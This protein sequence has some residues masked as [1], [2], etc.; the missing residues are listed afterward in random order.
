[1]WLK[2]AAAAKPGEG[3]FHDTKLATARFYAERELSRAPVL[4]RLVETGAESLMA[5]PAEAF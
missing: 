2:L 5:V 3:M 1:M 4:R